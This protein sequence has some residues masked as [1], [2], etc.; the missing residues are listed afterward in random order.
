M[1][2][3][4]QVNFLEK[5][6]GRAWVSLRIAEGRYHQVRKMFDAIGHRVTKLRR[7]AVGP[8]ELSGIEPGEWRYLTPKELRDLNEYLDRRE[9]ETAGQGPPPEA[10]RH[11]KRIETPGARARRKA[12]KQAIAEAARKKEA[13][14]GKAA[15]AAKAGERKGARRPK[16]KWKRKP[17]NPPRGGRS[18]RH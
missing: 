5:R 16:P 18:S 1:T 10:P 9:A 6:G 2:N 11:E 15:D 7:V 3:P 17:V 13:E 4:A 12:E 8:L 14:K